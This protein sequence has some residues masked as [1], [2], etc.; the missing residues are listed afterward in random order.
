MEII[1]NTKSSTPAHLPSESPS[2]HLKTPTPS[3]APNTITS[4]K[5]ALRDTRRVNIFVDNKFSF[6]LDLA[7]LADY[8]LR[9][10]QLLAPEELE[11]LISASNFGKLYAHTLEYVLTRPRSTQEVYDHLKHKQYTRKLQQ[12]RYQDFRERLKTDADFRSQV[13]T[14]KRTRP[15]DFTENNENEYGA[16]RNF[17][18]TKPASPI[19]DSDIT[20]VID[21]LS[22]RGYLDDE[23]FTRYY[24]ENRNLKKGISTKKLRLELRKKGI[25]DAII[26]QALSASPRDQ[27]TEVK[28]IIQKKRHRGYD[29]Q[30][31]IQYLLRQGFDY[32]LV[33]SSVL[34]ETD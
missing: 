14:H 7:Q 5:P 33:R 25:S 32:E 29:D 28:K 10:G 18:P 13:K 27:A 19:S 9:V 22:S 20:A 23:H 15:K 1:R 21:R 31:L 12:K 11:D 4:I 26:D 3:A 6:S 8:K 30:K 24:V 2:H 16:K 17:Y 34:D